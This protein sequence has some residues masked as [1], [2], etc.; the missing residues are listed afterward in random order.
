MALLGMLPKPTVPCVVGGALGARVLGEL[1]GLL[2]LHSGSL[3]T[4]QALFRLYS[5]SLRLH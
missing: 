5:A 1:A 2:R 4:L 3:Q